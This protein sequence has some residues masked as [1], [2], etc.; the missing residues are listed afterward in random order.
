MNL[1]ISVFVSC[2]EAII[3]IFLYNLDDSTFKTDKSDCLEFTV[4]LT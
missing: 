2:V 3:Y 4:N 1:K